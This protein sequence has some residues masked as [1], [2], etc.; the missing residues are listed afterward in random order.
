MGYVKYIGVWSWLAV[1]TEAE[2]YARR[3]K[4]GAACSATKNSR[5]FAKFRR[6]AKCRVELCK[7]KCRNERHSFAD[8]YAAR[9]RPLWIFLKG[10][11]K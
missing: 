9:Y 11:R 10:R 1:S 5:E 8:I 3:E 6:A 4:L 2:K 7:R